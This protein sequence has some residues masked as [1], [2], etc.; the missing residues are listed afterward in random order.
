MKYLYAAFHW[1][2][3]LGFYKVIC[4]YVA[5]LDLQNGM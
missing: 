1:R 5:E 3:K 4:K 2:H